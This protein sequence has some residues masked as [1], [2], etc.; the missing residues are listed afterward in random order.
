MRNSVTYKALTS[1][2]QEHG[3]QLHRVK[4]SHHLFVHPPSDTSILLP[5]DS[6]AKPAMPSQVVA[7]RRVLDERGL[8]ADAFDREIAGAPAKRNGRAHARK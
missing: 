6:S 4:G 1:F 8:A 5:A 2:L 7:V 3:F